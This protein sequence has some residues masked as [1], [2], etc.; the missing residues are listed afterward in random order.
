MGVGQI[1]LGGNLNP[2]LSFDETNMTTWDNVKKLIVQKGIKLDQIEELADD[3]ASSSS[4]DK[5][6]ALEFKCLVSA[7]ATNACQIYQQAKEPKLCQALFTAKKDKTRFLANYVSNLWLQDS[8]THLQSSSAVTIVESNNM[9]IHLLRSGMEFIV[10]CFVIDTGKRLTSIKEK[11]DIDWQDLV[12]KIFKLSQERKWSLLHASAESTKKHLEQLISPPQPSTTSGGDDAAMGAAAA[13]TT[14][15]TTLPVAVARKTSLQDINASKRQE[16]LARMKSQA[17]GKNLRQV[18]ATP[19]EPVV[20]NPAA[21]PLAYS[22]PRV[23]V[24]TAPIPSSAPSSTPHYSRKSD[25]PPSSVADVFTATP[26]DPPRSAWAVAE[27]NIPSTVMFAAQGI[28]PLS[29]TATT[30]T[31]PNPRPPQSNASQRPQQRTHVPQAQTQYSAPQGRNQYNAPAPQGQTSTNG[32]AGNGSYSSSSYQEPR[33]ATAPPPWRVDNNR[34]GISSSSNDHVVGVGRG[35][36]AWENSG[37]SRSNVA[38]T[39]YD[40]QTDGGGHMA[41]SAGPQGGY[42]EGSSSYSSGGYN[43]GSYPSGSH[44]AGSY[45]SGGYPTAAPPVAA[46]PQDYSHRANDDDYYYSQQGS[47]PKRSSTTAAADQNYSKR[48]R[49]DNNNSDYHNNGPRAVAGQGPPPST[50]MD[51]AGRGRGRGSHLNMPA[52]MTTGSTTSGA[53]AAD[54]PRGMGSGSVSYSSHNHNSSSSSSYALPPLNSSQFAAPP[55]QQYHAPEVGRG[56]GIDD[57][58]GRGRGSHKNLPAWMTNG[59]AGTMGAAGPPPPT[60]AAVAPP[61]HGNHGGSGG[62]YPASRLPPPP[63][64]MDPPPFTNSS[65]AGGGSRGFADVAPPGGGRGRG[66]GVSNLPAWMTQERFGDDV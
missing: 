32:G 4:S 66:R 38:T 19:P 44:M 11:R 12:D 17:H 46:T 29:A 13:P 63:I 27:S 54:G 58:R 26:K 35:N 65:G 20:A 7:V 64:R 31:Q 6:L 49:H 42:K 61:G 59:T 8:I 39:S 36:V 33:A 52:W 40:N 48:P 56:G 37:S 18:V 47:H 22:I 43:S 3:I 25:D 62:H 9:H 5:Q 30:T 16:R 60:A 55:P 10:S 24:Q 21:T 45:S 53:N 28:A 41:A 23:A 1:R 15:T 14:T 34:A 51:G 2:P 57:N 50:T